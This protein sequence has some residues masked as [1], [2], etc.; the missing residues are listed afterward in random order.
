M[1]SRHKSKKPP[2]PIKEFDLEVRP[3]ATSSS[4]P[5]SFLPQPLR[6]AYQRTNHPAPPAPGLVPP[7]CSPPAG[8]EQDIS[9]C[10]PRGI[11]SRC[12]DQSIPCDALEQMSH[13]P[14]RA[15]LLPLFSL[16]LFSSLSSSACL[17][18]CLPVSLCVFL[19][20]ARRCLS[21]GRVR[22]TVDCTVLAVSLSLFFRLSLPVPVPV[23][24]SPSF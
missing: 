6:V 1:S 16:P 17:C 18:L 20:V 22:S 9:V 11:C 7:S 15:G 23:P 10:G 21:P 13:G 12:V 14:P 24:P 5:T 3:L 2:N 8:G 19:P 4:Q